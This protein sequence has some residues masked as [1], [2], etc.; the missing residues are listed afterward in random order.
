MPALAFRR[1]GQPGDM[2]VPPPTQSSHK[3]LSLLSGSFSQ[4]QI[5]VKRAVMSCWRRVVRGACFFGGEG[6]GAFP[7]LACRGPGVNVLSLEEASL[8]GGSKRARVRSRY[9][10]G[11]CLGQNVWSIQRRGIHRGGGRDYAVGSKRRI[12]LVTLRG[13]RLVVVRRIVS[14]RI[15]LYRS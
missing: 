1:A 12:F 2:A 5:R 13:V 9:S 15:S 7:L 11:P 3:V 4:D 8:G 6:G 14:V 10:S